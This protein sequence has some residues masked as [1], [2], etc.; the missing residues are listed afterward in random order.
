MNIVLES[1]TSYLRN[2]ND[3]IFMS[4]TFHRNNRLSIFT[5]QGFL[6]IFH[7]SIAVHKGSLISK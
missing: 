2:V 7:S 6:K 1:V 5:C 3:N 4:S